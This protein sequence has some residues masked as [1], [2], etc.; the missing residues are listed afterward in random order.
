MLFL[1]LCAAFSACN[2]RNALDNPTGKTPIE[3]SVGGVDSP[4]PALTRAV[5]TDG[6]NKTLSPFTAATRLF[7]YMKSEDSNADAAHTHTADKYALTYVEAAAAASGKSPITT[8]PTQQLY[9]DDAHSRCSKLTVYAFAIANKQR[10]SMQIDK[11]STIKFGPESG[12]LA[13]VDFRTNAINPTFDWAIGGGDNFCSQE[14]FDWGDVV[15]SNNI[16]NNTSYSK[17]DGRMDFDWET[18]SPTYRKFDKGDLIFYHALTKVT[19]H[20]VMGEGF[21]ESDFKFNTNTNIKL[22]GFNGSGTFDLAQGEF[23]STSPK[24]LNYIA[25]QNPGLKTDAVDPSIK[26]YEVYSYLVPG[27][28]LKN[29]TVAEALTLLVNNNKYVIPMRTLYDKLL[30]NTANQQDASTVKES[31]LTDGTSMKAGVNYLFTI[32]IGKTKINNITAQVADWETVSAEEFTPTN[33]RIE[34]QLEERGSDLTNSDHLSLYRAADNNAGDIDDNYAVYNW[35]TGYN[36]TAMTPSYVAETVDKPAHWT[37]T[38]YW[39]S[40]KN[41]YHFRALAKDNGS[42]KVVV[43]N[44]V[45]TDAVNGD[46]YTLNSGVSYDD[47]LWGAPMLDVAKNETSDATT[48]K[49]NYGPDTNGFDAKDDGTVASGLTGSH[50]I[51]KAIGPTEDPV[52][53]ILFHM[54]SDLSITLST[55]S[56]TDPD[57]VDFGDGSDAAHSTKIELTEYKA[58][59]KLLLG[60]GLVTATS[61]AGTSTVSTTLSTSA[62]TCTYGAIPQSLTNVVLVITTPDHNQYK[63]A[64]KD[65]LA[66]ASN[67]VSNNNIANPYNKVGGTGA[68]KDKYIIDRWYP[69]FKYTYTFTLKKKGIVDLQ[70]TIVDWENVTAGD[71]NVQIQ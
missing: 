3:L 8:A 20:V 11:T 65:V 62:L 43:P 41:F 4:E 64:M 32:N 48:L 49:W 57:H 58:D 42:A 60:N 45:E 70:A 54:M 31:V 63:V 52:K 68:N 13:K 69:G 12:A 55:T 37:T 40:N 21:T 2:E 38:W 23:T 44:S 10:G 9:W 18:S 29:S 33:A 14:I 66:A 71:D 34:L 28:D 25:P 17:P 27:T 6:T 53:L 22:Q 16:A 24:T 51:Y 61:T 5:I 26:Y 56:N 15:F 39:D 19:F 36:P 35:T 50:Q 46:Y 47:I 59:G 30:E 67:A 1:S 7:L